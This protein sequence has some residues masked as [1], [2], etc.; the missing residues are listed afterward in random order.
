MAQNRVFQFEG[1]LRLWSIPTGGGANVP[2]LDDALDIFGN[3]PIEA[4]ASIFGYE[5]GELIEVK[6][7]R[8]DRYN[9]VIHSEQQPGTSS[10]SLTLVAVP[11]AIAA[12][13]FYGEAAAVSV[14]G[15]AIADESV[16]FSADELSQ[17]LAHDRIAT[18][19][20]PSVT[21]TAEDTTYVAGTD[22][23]IDTRLGRIRRLAGGAITATQEVYVNYTYTS[24][25]LTS[26][27]GG[28]QPQQNFYILGDMKNRPDAKD[29]RLEIFQA[30]LSTDGEV[31]LFSAEPLNITLTGPLIT[32]EDK[33]EPYVVKLHD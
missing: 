29:M 3:I 13:I 30:N 7:K 31:D 20:A 16:T 15:A 5:A 2:I 12:R 26:I 21:N 1:D 25:T 9:Q 8:R 10:L 33:T 14:T 23:V 32:P 22:Y 11:P 18:S 28:V 27:R 24:Y 17:P 19:P 6:S 4:S